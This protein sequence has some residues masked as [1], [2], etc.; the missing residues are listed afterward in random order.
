MRLQGGWCVAEGVRVCL[1]LENF[2]DYSSVSG[3]VGF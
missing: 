2:G 1:D 3:S